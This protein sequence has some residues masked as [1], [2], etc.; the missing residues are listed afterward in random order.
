MGNRKTGCR[1]RAV[2]T[3]PLSETSGKWSKGRRA[4]FWVISLHLMLAFPACRGPEGEGLE[5]GLLTVAGSTSVQPFAEKLAEEFMATHPGASINVQGGGSSA[6]IR[7]AETGAAQI[8]MSSRE[9]KPK[10]E[11]LHK[12][13]IAYDGIAVIVHRDNPLQALSREEIAGIF[14]GEIALWEEVGG[15]GGDIHFVAR[16]EGSGTR[17]AF[18]ELVMGEVEIS[19]RALVQASNGAVREIVA[20]DP[21]A[22]GYISL[23]LV[24][25]RVKALAVDGVEAAREQIVAKKYSL[26]RPFLFLTKESPSGAPAEFI[27]FVMGPEGQ[28]L[29]SAEGLIPGGG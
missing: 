5:G 10:E 2:K 15:A 16:E 24:D 25:R 7:A 17:G 20:K 1:R 26:V 14:A 27:D 22:I 6:G 8:G 19:L 4:L 21:G 18:E 13:V 28:G 11:G 12:N 9:L 3:S 23:G 29:L